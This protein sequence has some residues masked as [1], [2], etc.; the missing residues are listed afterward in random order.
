MYT[1]AMGEIPKKEHRERVV[2]R[3]VTG[4]ENEISIQEIIDWC[5]HKMARY[6]IHAEII[7]IDK[8]PRI[9]VGKI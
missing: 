7:F 2:C 4:Q 1:K 5:K 6:K 8:I 9:S 3:I